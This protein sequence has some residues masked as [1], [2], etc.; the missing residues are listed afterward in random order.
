MMKTR[1]Q[2]T[3]VEETIRIPAWR[4]VSPKKRM[5]RSEKTSPRIRPANF[6]ISPNEAIQSLGIANQPALFIAS[7]PL[8]NHVDLGMR[9]QQR[10]REDV[11][12][13][14]HAQEGNDDRLVDGS[15]HALR[16]AGR[17]HALVTAD[18]RDDRAEHR[19]FEDRPPEVRDRRVREEGRPE[20]A[21]RLVVHERREDAAEDAEE[22]RVDVE[23]ARHEHQGQEAG[24][25][26]VLDRVDAEHLERVQ[27]L[28]D[29][30]SPEV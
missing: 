14:E 17:G 28:T 11:V 22:Q 5:T 19:A 18:D 27:L 4:S 25:D 3:I 20:R 9:R 24:D 13:R 6:A 1:P 2:I 16:A 23:E 26:E 8:P 21:E 30:A 12:E 10:L 7:A 15:T 29:L